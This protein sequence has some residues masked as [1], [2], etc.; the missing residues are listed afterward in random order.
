MF[1]WICISVTRRRGSCM[2]STAVLVCTSQTRSGMS[3]WV[4]SW[5]Y[6]QDGLRWELCQC[7]LIVNCHIEWVHVLCLKTMLIMPHTQLWHMTWVSN[8]RMAGDCFDVI[9]DGVADRIRKQSR[10]Q[11]LV[12]AS[13]QHYRLPAASDCSDL[14]SELSERR[15]LLS[16]PRGLQRPASASWP[17]SLLPLAVISEYKV[18]ICP[19]MTT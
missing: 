1:K 16:A 19:R 17:A 6:N 13:M 14:D 4:V 3:L 18:R 9:C 12:S 2:T 5:W 11:S 8:G 7:V 15:R 10:G